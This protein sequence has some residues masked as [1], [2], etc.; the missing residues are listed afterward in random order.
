MKMQKPHTIMAGGATLLAV[1]LAVI[2]ENNASAELAITRSVSAPPYSAIA[3]EGTGMPAGNDPE[4]LLNSPAMVQARQL[5]DAAHAQGGAEVGTAAFH[6]F[7]GNAWSCVFSYRVLHAQLDL[8]GTP[9][10]AIL[11]VAIDLRREAVLTLGV[12]GT[13]VVSSGTQYD[14][15]VRFNASIPPYA[16]EKQKARDW[17][18]SNGSRPLDE[19]VALVHNN[20][21]YGHFT[22]GE[23][24]TAAASGDW[25][26]VVS[27]TTFNEATAIAQALHP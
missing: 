24:A 20:F 5:Q 2:V 18:I 25:V 8:N 15:Q 22:Y 7:P 14:L 21:I 9:T 10:G 11:G 12:V 3:A 23:I 27:G 4:D 13:N 6:Q 26:T 16:Q 17:A 1:T 19:G